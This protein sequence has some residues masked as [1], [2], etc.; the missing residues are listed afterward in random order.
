M[1]IHG[2]IHV[3]Y[4]KTAR[5]RRQTFLQL[6]LFNWP[7]AVHYVPTDK[8][9]ALICIRIWQM[10]LHSTNANYA[11]FDQLC[12]ITN[13]DDSIST[14]STARVVANKFTKCENTDTEINSKHKPTWKT[15]KVW[16]VL[17]FVLLD[18][19]S[20]TSIRW[21][22]TRSRGRFLNRCG[23]SIQWFRKCSR[24]CISLTHVDK[25]HIYLSLSK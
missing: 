17:M 4:T 11:N 2:K 25:T 21:E 14:R 20:L 1:R 24:R 12:H 6:N 18:R 19:C 8:I 7:K 16:T 13:F 23:T 22:P 9:N 15:C 3:Q 10:T 5:E